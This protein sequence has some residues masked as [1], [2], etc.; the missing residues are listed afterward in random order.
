MQKNKQE[1]CRKWKIPIPDFPRMLGS[2]MIMYNTYFKENMLKSQYHITEP[3]PYAC[4]TSKKI[5]TII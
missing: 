3:T 1:L 2:Y 5:T 4:I